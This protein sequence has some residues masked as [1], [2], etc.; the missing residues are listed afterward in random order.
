MV[1]IRSCL[2]C[3]DREPGCHDTCERYEQDK[4]RLERSRTKERKMKAYDVYMAEK[5]RRHR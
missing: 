2:G 4:A 1:G 5:P 3:K